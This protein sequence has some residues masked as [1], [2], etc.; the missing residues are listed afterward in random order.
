MNVLG[1]TGDEKTA[2][3]NINFVRSSSEKGTKK[4]VMVGGIQG[5][6]QDILKGKDLSLFNYQKKVSSCHRLVQFMGLL[7]G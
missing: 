5:W 3:R 2:T 7:G 6:G 1:W 4:K